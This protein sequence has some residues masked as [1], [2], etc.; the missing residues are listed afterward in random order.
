M[1]YRYVPALPD[2]AADVADIAYYLPMYLD[3]FSLDAVNTT[4]LWKKKVGFGIC[5]VHNNKPSNHE[6]S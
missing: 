3:M 6:Q 1:A 5:R 4:T 2:E